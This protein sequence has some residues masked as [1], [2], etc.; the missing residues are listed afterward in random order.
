[1]GYTKSQKVESLMKRPTSK[2]DTK[3]KRIAMLSERNPKMEFLGIMHHFNDASLKECFNLLKKN[4]AVGTDKVT[5]KDYSMNLDDNIQKLI[6]QMKNMAYRPRSVKQIMIPKT[7]GAMRPLGIS[8]FEDKI[9]QKMTQRI[10]ES[11]YEPLF[12]DCSY[13]FRP[14]RSCHDA[15]KDL[16]DYLYKNEIKTVIDV[17]IKGF[18]DNI[19]HKF[20]EEFLREKIKD[21]CF[22]RYI[23]RM[24]KAGILTKDELKISMEGVPQGSICS[25]ILANIFAHHVI[26]LWLEEMVKPNIKSKIA[27]FRYCD[28]LVI[29]CH[30]KDDAMKIKLALE[31]RLAKYKLELNKEKTKLVSFSKYELK[32]GITQGTFDFLGFT[33]YIDKTRDKKFLV[34]K[35]KTIKKRFKSKLKNVKEWIKDIRNKKP[36]MFI[37]DKFRSKIRGHIQY[38]GISF[39]MENVRNFV[40]KAKLIFFKWINR[41]SQRKSFNWEKW[42]LFLKKFPSPPTKVCHKLF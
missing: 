15:I 35:V 25:P 31:K 28:D 11:I 20:L 36:L 38:Y 42:N 30:N 13:G 34:V 39:N 14:N 27:F 3:L 10:L 37:W 40:Y 33:F 6:N 9:V 19:D 26:D 18:F 41:R 8:N 24:F 22:M 17:D 4:K 5:K 7:G 2:T 32:A 23:I 1:M 16:S 29:C 21:K 12:K